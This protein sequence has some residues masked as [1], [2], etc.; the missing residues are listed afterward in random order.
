MDKPSKPKKYVLVR[1][2]LGHLYVLNRKWFISEQ[3]KGV[4]EGAVIVA[5]SND[6]GELER[7]RDLTKES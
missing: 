6:M 5:E 1:T 4:H 7:F 3:A 2:E